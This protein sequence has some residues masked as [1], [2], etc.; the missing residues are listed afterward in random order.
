M[1]LL[2]QA[3]KPVPTMSGVTQPSNI[4]LTLTVGAGARRPLAIPMTIAPIS[5]DLQTKAVDPFYTTLTDDLAGSGVF[6]V[7]DP[8]LYPKGMRPP[9]NRE[10]GGHVEGH[11]GPV[12]PRHASRAGRR[13]R[14]GRGDALGPRDAQVH[15]EQ[16]VHRRAARGAPHRPHARERPRAPVH[17]PARARSSRRSPSLRPRAGRGEGGREGDLH[18]GLRRREPAAHDVLEHAVPRAGL[19]SGRHEARVPVL[20]EGHAGPVAHRKGRSRQASDPRPDAAQRV[21]VLLAR[22]QDR[23]PSAEA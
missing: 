14:D 13:E 5:P 21:A 12:P 20:R 2:G 1:P 23:S 10:E 6:V 8:S 19:V 17:G 9:Q 22:R 16:E 4:D 11:V 3:P 15:P 18:D 7:A